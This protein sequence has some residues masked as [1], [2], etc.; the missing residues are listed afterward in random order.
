MAA[1]ATRVMF[2]AVRRSRSGMVT[3]NPC[4]AAVIPRVN[5]AMQ[6]GHCQRFRSVNPASPP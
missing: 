4:R 3:C 6:A 2:R 1:M 5:T